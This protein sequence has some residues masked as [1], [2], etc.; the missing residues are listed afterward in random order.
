M[1]DIQ[2]RGVA[3]CV[4]DHDRRRLK[5]LIRARLGIPGSKAWLLHALDAALDE[6]VVVAAAEV[7]PGVVT[8]NARFRL[9][10]EDAKAVSEHALVFPHE[11]DDDLGRISILS[12]AGIALL[13]RQEGAR[14][15]WR[16]AGEVRRL[17][18]AEV[19]YQPDAAKW[20]P[21]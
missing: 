15:S 13:G 9:W 12:P 5:A 6:A 1:D 11:A 7:A 14:I 8:M 4:T 3:A 16:E 10:D 20:I 18:I 19:T 2:N 17:R 21:C